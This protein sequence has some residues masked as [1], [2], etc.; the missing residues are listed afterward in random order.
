[1]AAEGIEPVSH[2][3]PKIREAAFE[4]W[5]ELA[6]MIEDSNRELSSK[7]DVP[8]YTRAHLAVVYEAIRSFG[9]VFVAESAGKLLGYIAW[10]APPEYPKGVVEGLGTYV[11]PDER[12]N[13]VSRL[14]REAAIRYHRENGGERVFGVA[15]AGNQAGLE[16]SLSEGFEVVGQ[17]VRLK[18]G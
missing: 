12:K 2:N 5:N 10:V 6:R 17:L 1:M 4:D 11:V 15:H 16:S 18:L 7:Y 14:L 9:G 13:G 8:D 3:I